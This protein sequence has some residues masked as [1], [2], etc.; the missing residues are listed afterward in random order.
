MKAKTASWWSNLASK[1]TQLLYLAVLFSLPI[2]LGKHFWPSFTI[3]AGLR[4]DYLSPTIFVTDFLLV[5]LL[6]SSLS[7]LFPVRKTRGTLVFFSLCLYL[8]ITSGVSISPVN[9]VYGVVQLLRAGL[10]GLL[11]SRLLVDKWVRV[12]YLPVLAVSSS[13]VCLLAISQFVLQHSVGGLLYWVGERSFSLS[14]PGVADAS[15][16]GNLVLR[17]YATFPHPNVLAGYLVIVLSLLL[18]HQSF[19]FFHQKVRRS[20]PL[21]SM[22]VLLLGSV[23]LVLSLSRSGII[24]FIMVVLLWIVG[25]GANK[26]RAFGASL[27]GVLVFVLLLWIVGLSGRFTSLSLSDES[28]VLREQLLHTALQMIRRYPLFGVGLKNFLVALPHFQPWLLPFSS[29]Q[30]VHS[31]LVLWLAETG[32]VGLAFAGYFF[33]RTLCHLIRLQNVLDRR[34]RL[35]L[36]SA[37]CLLGLVDHYFL[38][39]PQGQL[40]LAFVF[41]YLWLPE[42]VKTRGKLKRWALH[43]RAPKNTRIRLS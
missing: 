3:I 21:C 4:V 22:S 28:V 17:P 27:V 30:P 10:F 24:A 15:L 7:L 13:L 11:T 5:L 12:W 19:A 41:G 9:S 1:R 2:Q 39:L 14:T 33:W 40:L 36:L 25:K 35:L 29:L 34:G 18:F 43:P 26:R 23:T 42:M 38:T 31:I 8:V 6:L 37:V 32:V 20:L 16:G